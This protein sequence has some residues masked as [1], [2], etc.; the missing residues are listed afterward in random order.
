MEWNK[1]RSLIGILIIIILL[2]SALLFFQGNEEKKGDK[3]LEEEGSIIDEYLEFS[4]ENQQVTFS[5][6]NTCETTIAVNPNDPLNVVSGAN[7][8]TTPTGDSWCGAYWS[9]DGGGTWGQTL[10]PGYRGGPA[11]ALTGYGIAGDP[12]V[13]FGPDGTCYMAGLAARRKQLSPFRPFQKMSCIWVARSR[14]GGE[15][16]DQVR[17]LATA[18]TSV[19]FH[20]KEWLTVDPNDGTL[21]VTWTVFNFLYASEIV[22]ARSTD[23]GNTWN[24][25]V[26]ISE[27]TEGETQTQGSYPVVDDQ[28]NVHVVWIEYNTNHIRYSKSTDKGLSFSTPMDISTVVPLPYNLDPHTYRTPT[29]PSLAVDRSDTNMSGSLY[30]TWPDSRNGDGDILLCYSRDSGSTWSDPVRVNNDTLENGVHQFFP[31]VSVN[32]K[33]DVCLIFY[34]MRGDP[35]GILLHVYFAMSVDGGLTFPINFNITNEMFDGE[36][37]AGSFLGQLTSS[38]HTAFIG[39]YIQVD[40][41]EIGAYACWCDVRNGS[42]SEYNSDVYFAFVEFKDI[43]PDSNGTVEE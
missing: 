10:I 14:D 43:Y 9:R 29:M 22:C 26:L 18:I 38:E 6:Q 3:D 5:K 23:G 11:S 35:E 39:D 31:S 7:D 25:Y 33:G 1:I 2:S 21:Y 19:N 12:V 36:N 24:D 27:I 28:G 15:T 42:P 13:V 30:V 40:T 32:P 41:N 20:D 34:D 4:G 8:Y 17:T 16:W 37:S